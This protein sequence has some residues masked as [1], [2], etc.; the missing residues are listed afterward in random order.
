[1]PSPLQAY[2]ENMFNWPN[3]IMAG[4]ARSCLVAL[5]ETLKGDEQKF[6]VIIP[7]NICPAVATS[8]K[9]AGADIYP[10]PVDAKT[11]L[12]SDHAFAD[13]IEKIEGRG[14]FMPTYLYG[15]FAQYPKSIKL[16][17]EGSWFV[18]ENDTCAVTSNLAQNANKQGAK[19]DAKLVSFGYAKNMEFGF[20]GAML[21]QDKNLAKEVEKRIATFKPIDNETIKHEQNCMLERRALRQGLSNDQYEKLAT[22]S[23]DE[24]SLARFSFPHESQTA[25]LE[26]L[27]NA[28]D[29]SQSRQAVLKLWDGALEP[30]KHVLLPIELEQPMAW[31]LIRRVEKNRD[32]YAHALRNAGFDAGVNYPSLWRQLPKGYLKGE[33]PNKDPWGDTVLNLWLSEDYNAERIKNAVNILQK[34][35]ENE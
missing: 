9:T 14:I 8:I 12:P 3:A 21:L 32:K 7:E 20:G 34:V 18:L 15:F 24:E 6:S 17:N 28:K 30:L 27:L 1:M 25:L 35:M 31:R 33:N 10:V 13:K 4:R 5:I 22:I 19:T 26:K 23:H 11:G 16:A 2:I 29:K